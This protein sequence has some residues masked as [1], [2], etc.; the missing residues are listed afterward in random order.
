MRAQSRAISQGVGLGRFEFGG[1]DRQESEQAQG[2][3]ELGKRADALALLVTLLHYAFLE[4]LV[5]LPASQDDALGFILGSTVRGD[6]TL[7]PLQL[8]YE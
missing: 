8:V 4:H 5:Q 6:D 3:L 2:L 7:Q 1:V